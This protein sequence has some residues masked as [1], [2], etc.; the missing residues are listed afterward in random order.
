M[1]N[2]H[3]LKHKGSQLPF[4]K[5]KKALFLIILPVL[6]VGGLSGGAYFY[7]RTTP[8]T[9]TE[10]Q[11]EQKVLAQVPPPALVPET[12]LKQ[13]FTT[14]DV[15]DPKVGGY[16]G[17]PDSDHLNNY[18]E[19]LYSTDPTKKDSDGDGYND[20]TEVTFGS[21]PLNRDLL[22][23][24]DSKERKLR[25]AGVDINY[26]D[27]EREFNGYLNHDRKPKLLEVPDSRFKVIENNSET[28]ENY[29]TAF[30]SI[31]AFE[32]QPSTL[33]LANSLFEGLGREEIEKF[34]SKQS[35]V[36]T[37]MIALPVPN[38]LLALHKMYLKNYQL[39]LS[40]AEYARAQIAQGGPVSPG[41]FYPELSMMLELNP[42][43]KQLKLD[44]VTKYHIPI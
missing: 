3:G 27:I 10:A 19:Y 2:F 13:Y 21:D 14:A 23:E 20:G 43:L 24:Q 31:T 33:Q 35:E 17:D 41:S 5:Q 15:N 40:M 38:G 29:Y 37:N 11:K 26:Q 1:A 25:R 22:S 32:D 34:I 7:F 16:Y 42:E 18:Q 4:L 6:T 39:V 28:L 12:W 36:V 8:P 44:A 9:E 30:K